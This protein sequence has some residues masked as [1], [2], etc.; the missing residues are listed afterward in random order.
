[1]E[2]DMGVGPGDP[3]KNLR[4]PG[5]WLNHRWGQ[6]KGEW[7]ER[8]GVSFLPYPCISGQADLG[9]VCG[10]GTPRSSREEGGESQHM[11]GCMQRG[12]RAGWRPRAVG[13][14]PLGEC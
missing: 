7:P 2:Q 6:E 13:S 5:G 3:K 8:T 10:V 1:M 12:S 11:P 4:V 9:P 14:Y